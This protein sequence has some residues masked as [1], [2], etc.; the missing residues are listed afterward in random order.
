MKCVPVIAALSL[1]LAVP[2]AAQEHVRQLGAHEHGRG[3]LNIA[4]E[5][6]RV[7]IELQAPGSDIS[8]SETK[9]DT[10]ERKAAAEAA[11]ATLEK[12]LELFRFPA[13]AGCTIASAKARMSIVGEDEQAHGSSGHAA[14]GH[15]KQETHG[16]ADASGDAHRG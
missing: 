8:R 7:A 3:F 11:I 6:N 12:P 13:E 15:A 16:H 14:E 10:P 9:P 1:F 2:L 5:G 4:V